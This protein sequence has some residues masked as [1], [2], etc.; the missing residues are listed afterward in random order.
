[1]ST[2]SSSTRY[3]IEP[4]IIPTIPIYSIPDQ[5]FPVHRIYCV[6]RNYAEHA[7]E[8]GGDPTR[9]MPFF[10][11]KPADAIVPCAVT[12]NEEGGI[13][14]IV[15]LPYPS[16]TSNLHYEVEWVVAMASATSVYGYAVG[17]DLTRRD[18]Q[19]IAKKQSRPW[20]SAKAFDRSAPITSIRP[21]TT[22]RIVDEEDACLWLQVNGVE[23]QRVAPIRHMIWSLKEIIA[24]L[25]EQFEL[26]AGD[27]I[28][29]GTP[30]GV[31]PLVVGDTVVAGMDGVGELSFRIVE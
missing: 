30:A 24:S 19:A 14:P 7:Q 4:T 18:L 11:L 2:S 28:F 22:S 25:S 16:A 26:T 13:T 10:F 20:C 27:L 3:V 29:T 6:G 17:V 8:M 31:G 21:I 9:D 5:V 23:R 12:P 1:M 15:T